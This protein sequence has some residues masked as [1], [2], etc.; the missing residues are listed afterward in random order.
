V[1][2]ARYEEALREYPEIEEWLERV[3]QDA[4]A[5]GQ[6][7]E[8]E[9]QADESEQRRKRRW[10]G[11][12]TGFGAYGIVGG[13]LIALVFGLGLGAALQ[14]VGLDDAQIY[15]GVIWLLGALLFGVAGYYDPDL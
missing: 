12:L 4:L 5:V 10:R 13:A 3:R 2:E 9:R 15:L 11:A 8:R 6:R 1:S 7:Y 14:A